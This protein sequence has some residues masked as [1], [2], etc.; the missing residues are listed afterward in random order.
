MS[1]IMAKD[2]HDS[3]GWIL[4]D[5]LNHY[6]INSRY[7]IGDLQAHLGFLNPADLESWKEYY[8]KHVRTQEDVEQKG[9]TL[10]QNI[11]SEVLP[12]VG[13]INQEDCIRYLKNLIFEKTFDGY[14]LRKNQLRFLLEDKLK[15]TLEFRYDYPDDYKYKTYC[16][17]YYYYDSD[18]D[19][20]IGIKILPD[21]MLKK[22]TQSMQSSL[23]EIKTEHANIMDKKGGEFFILYYESV[24][25]GSKK[26][27][28]RDTEE[29]QKLVSLF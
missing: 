4:N 12:A 23:D 28:I 17:D 3:I 16:I 15:V 14:N 11:I 19:M 24:G 7:S 13:L 8:F 2:P 27:R 9:K 10:Y 20:L 25:K 6:K 29:Y 22:R 26:Y 5:L 18:K 1:T 21:T